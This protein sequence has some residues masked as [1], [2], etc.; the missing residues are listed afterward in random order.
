MNI[1]ELKELRQTKLD[2]QE[3]LLTLIDSEKRDF[4]E[5][6]N[7]NCLTLISTLRDRLSAMTKR[8]AIGAIFRAE[9]SP[10]TILSPR[11]TPVALRK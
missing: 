1:F 9:R 8:M 7:T 10:L 4:T 3:A 5:V 11:S 2:R 6:E